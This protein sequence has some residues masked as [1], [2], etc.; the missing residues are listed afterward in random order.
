[1]LIKHKIYLTKLV[2]LL[3]VFVTF[4]CNKDQKDVRQLESVI[5]LESVDRQ[6]EIF[7]VS[8]LQIAENDMS[9][10]ES[11]PQN[12]LKE[13]LENQGHNVRDVVIPTR[14]LPTLA[15][16]MI[17]PN[18]KCYDYFHVVYPPD[19]ASRYILVEMPC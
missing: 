13:L 2:A 12:F 1:M 19:E 14:F 3:I 4:G 11:S 6:V 16:D 8:N 15:E 5:Q 18:P 9:A 10:F 17:G 7:K